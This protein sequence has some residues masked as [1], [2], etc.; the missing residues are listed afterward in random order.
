MC[1]KNSIEK[2]KEDDIN[3]SHSTKCCSRKEINLFQEKI[4]RIFD[5]HE[6]LSITLDLKSISYGI[7]KGTSPNYIENNQV[8]KEK[9]FENINDLSKLRDSFN[10]LNS[11]S[12]FSIYTDLFSDF[13]V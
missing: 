6:G 9:S 2:V 5:L 1:S 12:Y 4:N 10:F 8:I 11:N 3:L 13:D 7:L